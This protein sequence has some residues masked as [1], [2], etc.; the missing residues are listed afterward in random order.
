[1]VRQLD[2]YGTLWKSLPELKIEITIQE[3]LKTND[4][5][6]DN[7]SIENHPKISALETKIDRSR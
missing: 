5:L 2:S 4:L 6:A 3:T 1:M 7:F